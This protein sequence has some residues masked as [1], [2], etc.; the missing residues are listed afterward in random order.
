MKKKAGRKELLLL[1]FCMSL[2]LV[3][4]GCAKRTDSIEASDS[5]EYQVDEMSVDQK[6]ADTDS[7]SAEAGQKTEELDQQTVEAEQTS[8]TADTDQKTT[9]SIAAEDPSETSEVYQLVV[10]DYSEMNQI[11]AALICSMRKSEITRVNTEWPVQQLAPLYLYSY[12][13]LF[14]Q[15]TFQTVQKEGG[16]HDTYRKVDASYLKN[17]LMYAFGEKLALEDLKPDG[18]LIL[19]EGSSY[20]IAAGDVN[21]MSVEYTGYEN[22]GFTE[23][24]VYSF[25]YE[26][27]LDD[28]DTEDGLVQVKFQEKPEVESGI[29]L[30]AVA[31]TQY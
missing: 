19:K 25:D 23:F 12:V 7:Q 5:G 13:N 11:L 4:A 3:F 27:T 24:T 14:D 22:A 2:G 21:S 28:G 31:V 29:V 16:T 10:Y 17:L 30:K 15:K 1:I 8:A 6:S 9:E 20:Y 26:M 18:D